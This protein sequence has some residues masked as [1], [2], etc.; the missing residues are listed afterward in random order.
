MY[1]RVGSCPLPLPHWCADFVHDGS[2]PFWSFVTVPQHERHTSFSMAKTVPIVTSP[3][4]LY[5]T[6]PSRHV[7]SSLYGTYLCKR[8]V[9][10]YCCSWARLTIA[11]H[12]YYSFY[13]F[14]LISLASFIIV[15][16]R[17]VR[18]CYFVRDDSRLALGTP[19]FSISAALCLFAFMDAYRPP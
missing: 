3:L 17:R 18:Q 10:M 7:L 4:V 13:S 15:T 9:C 8:Y 11:Y 14:L 12:H 1:R 2:A 5:C 16:G 19:S 6:I